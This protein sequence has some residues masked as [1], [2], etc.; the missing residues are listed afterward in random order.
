ME[1]SMLNTQYDGKDGKALKA[2]FEA[3]GPLFS[4]QDIASA[5]YKADQNADLAGL[6]LYDKQESTFTSSVTN[7][8]ARTVESSKSS[9]DTLSKRSCYANGKFRA[10]KQKWRPVS[11]GTISS[12][13]GKEY[14]KSMPLAN[15]YCMGKKPMKLDAKELPMSEIWGEETKV[16]PSKNDHMYKDIENFLF[17]MLGDGFQL[18]RDDIRGVLGISCFI[19]LLFFYFEKDC[20][21][22]D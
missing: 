14:T 6:I 12:I 22:G 16:N 19:S 4:P 18:E 8:G 9:Y 21:E 10:S 15:S 13:L 1:A 11:G 17:R 3:F 5:Y 7:G 20:G 2:L